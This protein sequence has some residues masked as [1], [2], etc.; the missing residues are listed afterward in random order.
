VARGRHGWLRR[1]VLVGV[2]V[3]VAFAPD[4]ASGAP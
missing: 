4:Q 3:A 1:W 2:L